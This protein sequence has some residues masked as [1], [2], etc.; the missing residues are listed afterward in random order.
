MSELME[1]LGYYARL[2]HS[3]RYYRSALLNNPGSTFMDIITASDIAYAITLMKNNY[4]VWTQQYTNAKENEKV[5][6]K[7]AEA[8]PKKKVKATLKPLFT[9]GKGKKRTF[10]NSTWNDEGKEFF[11]E[12]METWKCAFDRN[13]VQYRCL[14][15]HWDKWIETTGKDMLLD[16]TGLQ[17]KTMYDLLRVREEDEVVPTRKKK[18]AEVDDSEDCEY[19]SDPDDEAVDIGGWSKRRTMFDECSSDA[20]ED[21]GSGDDEH[22]N[23]RGNDDDNDDDDDEFLSSTSKEILDDDDN[24]KEK[25]TNKGVTNRKAPSNALDSGD[26]SSDEEEERSISVF[27]KEMETEAKAAGMKT[28]G[29]KNKATTTAATSNATE[30][31]RGNSRKRPT[32]GNKGGRN[33]KRGKRGEE[34]LEE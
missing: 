12:T 23:N 11:H 29:V 3:N 14:R 24:V 6:D 1:F 4:H 20:D 16:L 5:N 28:R 26:I 13:D 33:N 27:Q 30:D 34:L 15:R 31:K 19:E 21:G 9:A 8:G 22:K 18:S 7:D 17:N 10:G 32:A 2:V 25:S